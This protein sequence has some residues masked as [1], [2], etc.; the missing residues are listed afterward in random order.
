MS[1]GQLDVARGYNEDAFKK[2]FRSEAD[3]DAKEFEYNQVERGQKLEGLIGN[4]YQSAQ[5][6]AS[7]F[8]QKDTLQEFG[9]SEYEKQDWLRKAE[10]AA[11]FQDARATQMVSNLIATGE[12]RN[13]QEL[14]VFKED[15]SPTRYAQLQ[16]KLQGLNMNDPLN[17]QKFSTGISSYDASR[18]PMGETRANMEADIE[19][20]FD[21]PRAEELKRQLN[22]RVTATKQG[23]SANDTEVTKALSD[24]D[25]TMESGGYGVYKIAYDG[26]NVYWSDV[27]ESWMRKPFPWETGENAVPKKIKLDQPT[28]Q[29]L[30]S[31][32][33]KRGSIIEDL[34]T[35][36]NAE[37]QAESAKKT[38]RDKVRSKELKTPDAIRTEYRSMMD[39]TTV[40]EARRLIN[41]AQAPVTGD[42]PDTN[43]GGG[44]DPS[45]F[46][47]IY[48]QTR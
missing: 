17:F 23:M 32:K 9:L 31:K 29:K 15:M 47:S 1:Y 8:S 6:A 19:V 16:G 20:N 34:I 22:E 30:T 45:L 33:L 27:Q 48:N 18:D 26:K 3:R 40:N 28:Q 11:H 41:P 2:G 10:S 37:G 21:G 25:Y 14:S 13:E 5:Q 38:L 4:S 43:L 46:Q 36:G 12:I 7:L 44:I 39:G 24:V 42:L 35:K